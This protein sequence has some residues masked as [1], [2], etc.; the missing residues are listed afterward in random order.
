MANNPYVNK[1]QKADGSTLIDITSDTAT[2]S[3]VLSGKYFH[4]ASG[5][6]VKGSLNVPNVIDNLNS[7]STTDA[8]SANQGKVL[9]DQISVSQE[10][11]SNKSVSDYPLGIFPFY[12]P[13]GTTIGQVTTNGNARG[14]AVNTGQAITFFVCTATGTHAYYGGYYQ[15]WYLTHV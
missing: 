15:Q 2:E 1:V 12:I 13:T 3:D 7:S 4:K 9:H 10:Y 14:I 6:R 11:A 8:L 5:E